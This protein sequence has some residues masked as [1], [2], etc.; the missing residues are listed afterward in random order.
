[1]SNYNRCRS[2]L[3]HAYVCFALIKQWDMLFPEA[4]D[5]LH[6]V[7]KYLRLSPKLLT[8]SEMF[9]RYALSIREQVLGAQHIDVARTLYGLAVTNRVQGRYEQSEALY[10][11]AL[12]IY[13]QKLGLQAPKTRIS[14]L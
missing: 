8:E 2:L 5:L 4:A 13:E 9:Y 14:V 6:Q 1:M 12:A 11:Q 10:R 3:P 7:A